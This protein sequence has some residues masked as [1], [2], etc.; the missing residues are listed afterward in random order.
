MAAINW[1]DEHIISKERIAFTNQEL[2]IPGIRLF[3]TQRIQNAI[4]PLVPHFHENA[5]EFTLVTKGSMTF[6]TGGK[7]YNVPGGSIFVSFPNEVH[8]TNH[9]PIAINNIYWFQVEIGNPENFLFLNGETGKRLITELFSIDKHII[10]TDNKEIRRITE[11]AFQLCEEGGNRLQIAGYI[12]IFFQLLL[13]FSQKPRYHRAPDI[14]RVVVYIRE[15]ITEELFLDDLAKTVHLSTSQFKQKFCHI[16]GVPPRTYINER[17]VEY[18]KKLLLEGHS[19]TDTAMKLGFNNSSYFA[20]V[21][22]K[23]TMQTPREYVAL[24]SG[25]EIT[26]PQILNF[27]SLYTDIPSRYETRISAARS[28]SPARVY[29]SGLWLMPSRLGTNSMAVS[30][31][32]AKICAS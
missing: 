16:V 12:L 7:E 19:V 15:H 14:E 3:A 13:A 4:S 23:H 2:K 5:F 21:F 29:S 24:H 1:R 27:F 22:K 31:T 26:P 30:R 28:I 32:P 20:T 18:A 6:Y 11:Q 17:K 8:S 25:N 10:T 9:V